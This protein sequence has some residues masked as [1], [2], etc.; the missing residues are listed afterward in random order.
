MSWRAGL[1]AVGYTLLFLD[2]F[3]AI[4]LSGALVTGELDDG[5]MVGIW[6]ASVLIAVFFWWGVFS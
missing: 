5:P 6:L 2:T 3:V 4:A 1:A